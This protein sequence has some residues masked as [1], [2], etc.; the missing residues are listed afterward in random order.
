[1]EVPLLRCLV[2]RSRVRRRAR[3]EDRLLL[4]RDNPERA[5]ARRRVTWSG[6]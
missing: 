2:G 3:A 6:R 5:A 4:E 1:M